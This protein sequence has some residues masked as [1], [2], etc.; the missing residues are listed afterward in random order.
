VVALEPSGRATRV[1][2][3]IDEPWRTAPLAVH[4]VALVGAHRGRVALP[5]STPNE[6]ATVI[7]HRP[8]GA[9]DRPDRLPA[10]LVVNPKEAAGPGLPLFPVVITICFVSTVLFA[11]AVLRRR[12][13]A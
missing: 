7:V 2:L 6:G 11:V 10:S 4:L 8:D 5:V 12:P 3:R 13:R 1:L 9:I